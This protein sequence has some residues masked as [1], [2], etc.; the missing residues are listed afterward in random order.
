MSERAFTNVYAD[1]DYAASYA[2][3]DWGGT[4]HLV[5]RDL[6][7]IVERH[8]TGR[9]ALDFGCGTGRSTRLLRSYGLQVTGVD[10][11]ESMIGSARRLDP[12]GDYRLLPPGEVIE[13]PAGGFDLIL[14]AF[15]FDNIPA[16]EK[17]TLLRALGQRLAPTG[18][19]INIVSSPEIYLHEWASFSTAGFP[20]NAEAKSGD[21]V[22]IVT[23]GFDPATPCEDILCTPE[24]YRRFYGQSG[25][26]IVATE[27]P[28]GREGDGIAYR[29][30]TTI[31]PWTIYVLAR[32]MSA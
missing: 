27:R 29:S 31:A 8:V 21:I 28:L 22:R 7:G 2:S 30:E 9:R 3:L 10:I 18:R 12:D 23:R 15:P 11:A 26:K 24:S 17:V 32:E 1:G 20:E 19:L 6:P 16:N 5:F 4:Y 14:A 25:L 13:R